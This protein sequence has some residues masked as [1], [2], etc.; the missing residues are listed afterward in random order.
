MPRLPEQNQAIKDKRRQKLM[1]SA[2]KVFA[3]KDYSSVTIDNITKVS[4]CSH[5]LFY[6][7]FPSMGDMLRAVYNE[8]ILGSR[9]DLH[10]DAPSALHGAEGLE[11][12]CKNVE[13][14]SSVSGKD[15]SILLA[16][17]LISQSEKAEED[18][19]EFR[20]RFDVRPLYGR[21]IREGQKEGK[22]IDG[23]PDDLVRALFL[24]IRGSLM[25]KKISGGAE[26][27]IPGKILYRMFVKGV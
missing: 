23:S 15:L 3:C 21:L 4:K 1:D 14:M 26:R 25:R 2:L 20:K 19:P 13:T 12:V 17:L 10:L 7:Y 11:I 18:C 24:L 5:G 6:H 22:V 9:I 8:I 16:V 27:P